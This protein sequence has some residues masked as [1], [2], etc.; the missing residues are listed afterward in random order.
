MLQM[1]NHYTNYGFHELCRLQLD[2]SDL[3]FGNACHKHVI[4][5][6]VF[7]YIDD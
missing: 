5:T 4:G 6:V 3:F 1:L 7:S 2:K